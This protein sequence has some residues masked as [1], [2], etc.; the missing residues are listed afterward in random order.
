MTKDLNATSVKV[1]TGE[2]YVKRIPDG[3]TPGLCLVVAV[4]PEDRP[5]SKSWAFR[6]TSPTIPDTDKNG[7]QK[8]RI[9]K[10]KDTGEPVGNPISQFK[11]SQMTIG[12]YPDM[13][14]SDARDVATE[15]RKQVK[16]GIDPVQAKQETI[17]VKRQ[18]EIKE[19]A[20][21]TVADLFAVYLEDLRLDKKA[22]H[23]VERAYKVDILPAIGHLKAKEV[24]TD[25]IVDLLSEIINPLSHPNRINQKRVK[26][27]DRVAELVRGYLHRAY[28]IGLDIEGSVRWAKKRGV[29]CLLYNPVTRAKLPERISVGERYLTKP[30]VKRLWKEVGV[31]YMRPDMALAIKL[32][33]ATGQRV[34]EVLNAEWNEFDLEDKVWAIPKSRT[35]SRHNKKHQEPHL[36]P[37]TDF[38][39]GLLAQL[40]G[41]SDSE[42]LFP[43]ATGE[44]P[45]K[46]GVLSDT[47]DIFCMPTKQSTRKPFAKFTP[48]DIRRTWKTLSGSIGIP[49][50]V[51]DRIQGHSQSDI[52]SRHYDRYDSLKEKREAMETYNQWLSELVDFKQA[53][54]I[55]I[56]AAK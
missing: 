18:E 5:A 43:D 7:I 2:N 37:L 20:A 56:R 9:Y 36:V 25:N 15:L 33:L 29:F 49:K 31:T 47:V 1:I 32:L 51:R 40:R 3:K 53:D 55:D 42:F 35:K 48:R 34:Q 24:T 10:D 12:H 17:Q 19:A 21:G 14:L 16:A 27:A 23:D 39:I 38:T 6:Y 45:K 46:Y 28:E 52:S 54:V 13:K 8:V 41:L 11:R 30:E 50:D 22:T 4:K 26:P 44:Q